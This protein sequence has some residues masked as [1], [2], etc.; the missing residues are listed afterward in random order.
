M[1]NWT[2]EQLKTELRTKKDIKGLILTQEN[3]Q[4]R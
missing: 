4:R 3:L 1:A 2:L